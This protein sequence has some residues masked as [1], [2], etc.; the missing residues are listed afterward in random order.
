[1][2]PGQLQ[3]KVH[4]TSVSAE[5]AECCGEHL[6]SQLLW[7]AYIVDHSPDQPRQ[8]KGDPISKITRAAR[9]SWFTPVILA[10]QEA[11]QEDCSLRPVKAN[12]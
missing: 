5:K 6:S 10:T 4:E 3:Q 9:Y 12:S 11:E 7:E 2:V 1:V 8:K